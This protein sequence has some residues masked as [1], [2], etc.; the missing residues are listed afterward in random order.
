MLTALR[1]RGVVRTN[2]LIFLVSAATLVLLFVLVGL[3]I[4]I[5]Y[6]G[7]YSLDYY[8]LNT[9][10]F[11]ALLED[12]FASIREA[13][14]ELD[15]VVFDE[16]GNQLYATDETMAQG[17]HLEDA[18]FISEYDDDTYWNIAETEEDG[19][20]RYYITKYRFNYDDN[21]DYYLGGIQLDADYQVIGGDLL[22]D[23]EKL[24]W[25]Q[26]EMMNNS[27]TTGELYK[28]EYENNKGQ[29][30]TVVYTEYDLEYTYQEQTR[31]AQRVSNFLYLLF[32]LLAAAVIILQAFW[33]RRVTLRYLQPL[34]EAI[35]S[36]GK[37]IRSTIEEKDLAAEFRPVAANFNKLMDRLDAANEEKDHVY[38]ERQRIIAD[39]SH[40][41]RT[42]LTVIQGYS[43]AFLEGR[44]PEDKEEQY[45]NVIHDKSVLSTDMIN[46]LFDFTKMEHPDFTPNKQPV[47]LVEV[48]LDYLTGKRE[49]LATAGDD[50]HFALPDHPI[51]YDC[52]VRLLIRLYENLIGNAVKHNDPGTAIYF[53]LEERRFDIRI[54]I[55]DNGKGLQ[56]DLKKTLFNPFVTGNAARTS[57]GGTGL[58]MA[59]S[60]RIV[61]LHDG[62]I[63]LVD[64]PEE[65][66]ATEFEIIFHKS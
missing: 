36:Y 11:P 63:R 2:I 23:R 31:K 21:E 62:S 5:A 27:Y 30:R 1:N 22:Q 3:G 28:Y 12:D 34:D 49:E 17:Y 4:R 65:G 37:G 20:T 55:A 43:Q 8:N 66:R 56:D 38:E 19:E 41:L 33:M 7:A 46:M 18:V 10:D 15:F 59:I 14:E 64:P 24:T 60:K 45:M 16:Q 53:T 32:F 39:V 6:N 25:Q 29:L 57:G 52:D 50:L 42:P 47:N 51:T 26:I 58:G 13:H 54:T 35:T 44:V 48:T 61:D 40:D 9:S